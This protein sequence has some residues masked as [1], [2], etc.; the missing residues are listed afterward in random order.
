MTPSQAGRVA[1]L[2]R[3]S[4]EDPTVNAVRGQAGL[5]NKFLLEVTAAAVARG[6]TPND[7]ELAR[8][9]DCAYRAHMTRIRSGSATA[10]RGGGDAA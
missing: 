5:R 2:T 8:R 7:A 1:A 3:W 9:A 10:R 4:Q 6:E